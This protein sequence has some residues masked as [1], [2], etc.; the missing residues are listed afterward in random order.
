[1][2]TILRVAALLLVPVL[3]AA[4]LTEAG[5][6]DADSAAPGKDPATAPATDTN[7]VS[8]DAA[9]DGGRTAD[10]PGQPLHDAA[11]GPV[12]GAAGR[13]AGPADG[14][15]APDA[16][17]GDA[18]APDGTEGDADA[19]PRDADVGAEQD[20]TVAPTPDAAVVDAGSVE[21]AADSTVGLPDTSDLEDSVADAD[22]ADSTGTGDAAPWLDTDD[23]DV[24][25]A[26][27]APVAPTVCPKPAPTFA[28][29]YPIFQ[30]HCAVCHGTT[31]G[32][33]W[34]LE[35]YAHVAAWKNEVRTELLD[36]TMPPAESTTNFTDSERMQILTWIFCGALK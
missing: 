35:T 23:G 21:D 8:G 26:I 20:A 16:R 17:G 2:L 27:C 36:C 25:P 22:A 7:A 12:D 19:T 3:C 10:A 33:P 4:C 28:D 18:A 9:A 11:A 15:S 14:V 29:V 1:M 30:E 24:A 6:A 34:P 5:L 32:G 31:P 13:P